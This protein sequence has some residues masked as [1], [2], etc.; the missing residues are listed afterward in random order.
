LIDL[1]LILAILH[2]DKIA[3]DQAADVAQTQLARDFI[4][5]FQIGLENRLLD[6]TAALVPTGI[7]VDRD[8]RSS[9][10]I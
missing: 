3:N 10:T 8:Q 7:Y 1:L 5:R 4:G 6:V 9:I 2:V